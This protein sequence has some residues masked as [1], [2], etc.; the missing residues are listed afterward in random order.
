[1]SKFKIGD[2]VVITK[3]RG[4]EVRHYFPVG[5]VVRIVGLMQGITFTLEDEKGMRQ[6]VQPECFR[7]QKPKQLENK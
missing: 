2:K 5:V 3:D 4:R 1:M 7:L 6:V